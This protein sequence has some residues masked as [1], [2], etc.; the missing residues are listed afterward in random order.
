[1][2]T[3]TG[4]H[5]AQVIRQKLA[6][7]Q[8]I[9]AGLDENIC[10]RAPS[11]RW[12]PKEI[13]SHLWG[14]EGTGHLPILQAFLD[15]ETPT[16]DIDPENPFFSEQRSRMTFRQLLSEVESEY[17]GIARFAAD[18]TAEQLQRKAHIPKLKESPLGEY[19]TLEQMVSGLGE[20]HLQFHIDHLREILQALSADPSCFQHML[21]V[22]TGAGSLRDFGVGRG[23]SLA[24]KLVAA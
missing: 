23:L 8:K 3:A 4:I 1:M 5:L 21:A 14:P 17:D 16:I 9:C 11:G 10:S 19:P 13:L 18:L 24:W 7:L 2:T 15:R 12:S 22:H 6:E 20:Y